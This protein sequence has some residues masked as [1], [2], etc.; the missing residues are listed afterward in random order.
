MSSIG[1]PSGIKQSNY[2]FSE[3]RRCFFGR[4]LLFVPNV[5]AKTQSNLVE[6]RMPLLRPARCR[7]FRAAHPARERRLG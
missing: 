6:L 3:A 7:E 2:F 1:S 5:P 4:D